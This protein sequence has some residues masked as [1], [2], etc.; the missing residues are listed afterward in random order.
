MS[1]KSKKYIPNQGPAPTIVIHNKEGYNLTGPK[2]PPVATQKPANTS[3]ITVNLTKLDANDLGAPPKIGKIGLQELRAQKGLKQDDV[4]KAT[5]ISI[6]LIKSFED[7]SALATPDIKA[8]IA[9]VRQYL[10]K[11]VKPN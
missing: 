4:A 6:Q 8:K 10:E 7:G 9:K 11:Y 3:P 2:P 1:S 5:C